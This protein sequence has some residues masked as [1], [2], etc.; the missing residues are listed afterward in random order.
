MPFQYFVKCAKGHIFVAKSGSALEKK[1]RKKYPEELII[2]KVLVSENNCS[3]CN[4]GK[5]SRFADQLAEFY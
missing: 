1:C 3:R 2:D 5:R 4:P